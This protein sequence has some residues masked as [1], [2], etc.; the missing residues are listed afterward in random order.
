MSY[1]PGDRVVI[2]TGDFEGSVATV[3]EVDG[4]MLRVITNGRGNYEKWVFDYEVEP[5]AEGE[6]I[7]DKKR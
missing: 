2:V 6:C 4:Q 1:Q 7:H 5:L 3:Q